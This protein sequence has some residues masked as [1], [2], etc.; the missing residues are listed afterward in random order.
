M[1]WILR[2]IDTL[3]NLIVKPAKPAEPMPLDRA[4]RFERLAT[5]EAQRTAEHDALQIALVGIGAEVSAA[6]SIISGCEQRA[7]AV[8]A[9]DRLKGITIDA[10]MDRLN[11][12]I[13]E[14]A[15]ISIELFISEVDS[16]LA[17][18]RHA[19]ADTRHDGSD[20]D[21]LKLTKTPRFLSNA[22]SIKRR[23][24]ALQQARQRAIELQVEPL[25]TADIV[26]ALRQLEK[27]FPDVEL[28]PVR[29]HGA[30]VVS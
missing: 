24:A 14:T 18:W 4:Q 12:Q 20:R 10:E 5:L 16:E 27:S 28:E 7:A 22:G 2:L 8:L 23:V 6:R 17:R 3:R 21:Y 13:R 26:A 30:M 25:S 15:P 19:E 1:N 9:A 11:M 29:G